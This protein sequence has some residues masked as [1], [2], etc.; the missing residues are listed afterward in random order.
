MKKL[1]IYYS[2]TGNNKT[3]AESLAKEVSADT[4]EVLEKKE[5]TFKNIITDTIFG[6]H[7]PIN[8]MPI[9]VD[10][11]DLVI[12]VGPIWMNKV[13]APFRTLF[14][15]IKNKISNYT[16]IALS[17]GALG[18]NTRVYKELTKRLGKNI[19]LFLDLRIAQLCDVPKNPTTKETG[20]YLLKD[21]N[22]DLSKLTKMTTSIINNI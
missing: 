14:K 13:C 16:F 2:N 18:P 7:P 6:I 5:R 12:F 11:Y 22:S 20:S 17:G 15:Q 4:F 10:D 1:I 8:K 9:S 21:N 3:L 19:S